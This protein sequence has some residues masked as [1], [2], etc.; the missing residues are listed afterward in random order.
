[1][2]IYDTLN[3]EQRE[4]VFCTE[5]PLLML[6][7][8]G[9]G[10]TRSLTHR[11]AYLIEEKGVAPWNILAITFTNKAA[12]EMRER[13]DALVGYGSEDIWI[14]TFHAT[15]SRILRRHIDL[16]GYDRNFT[17][18]DASDQKSLMKE[19]LKEMKIDTKQFPERS[20]MSEISS[21]K[22]EYK[23]P[24]DYRNEYGSNFRN[25]RIADIYEHY[26][27]RLK[28]NNALDFDDLLVKMVDLFQTNPDVLEHYQD[29]FQYIM[30]DEYQDTNTVQFLLVSLLAK[31]YRNLCVVGDDDQS[32]YKFRGANIYNILN[33][34]K[35]FPDAQVIR[36][37]QNYR[38][39]QNILNAANGVIANNKGRK[40]KKLW[41]EN[42]KGELVH[43]KQY[44]TEYDEADGVVSRINF[45]AMRGVQY[46][47]MA[48]LYRTNAQS[49]IFEE[50]LKQKNIPY[51]I[52]RGISFYD[53]KEIKDLMSY[54][55]V[56]DS[57]MDDLSV[58][59]IINVPKR[60]IGQTTINRLQ[61][62]A[63]LNQMSFLDAVFNADE[64]PEVTRALAKLHKFADMIEEFREY[65]SE[66]EISELLEHILDVTQYRAEL[67][68]EG[69][70]E[71]ISRLEDIEELFNDIAYYEE[72][73]E[74]PN[75]RD[76]LAEK[77][78]YT[79]N[80]GIDNLEDENNKVLLMTLHNAKGLEF[81]NVFLG[82]MEEGV[83]PGF[84]AMMSGDESEIEEERRLCYVGITRAKERLFLS[85]AKRRMLRGQTQYNRR[86]RFIDEIPGQY[87]DTEQRVSEQRVVKNTE[88]PAKYQYGAK[89][90]KPYN[91]SDFKVKPVGELDYQVGDRVKHIKFGV[92]TVQEIT[93]G[94]RDF[95]VAVEFDRVGRKKMF[96]SF[97]KLKKVK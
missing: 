85:A 89:A 47:D 70:D 93:K 59:R 72:E 57:G 3:N 4:A 92:G 64:I 75:L 37:E 11:I 12:Q 15:C 53:R 61:E 60:G 95:E 83:F 88:R 48:I 34:E 36:L 5:G 81:N 17:I 71:S 97:A 39:T 1:M 29:R 41:T 76:F 23:S 74:N 55:K 73:E 9:S 25:Q 21:A 45:L 16:L 69:T 54:L 46:K 84:G 50:K 49:R 51:A 14:S 38:S 8:A 30:V 68:A 18:Y 22:N 32:I 65:A 13:V 42:Q 90:G 40:E 31:K 27:K 63:I 6:A 28:E 52:V 80:A 82:G 78:M 7:G 56:V 35:V 24:L 79:L 26:Q 58:K 96:A 87:L 86:S 33:F 2:S 19:V 10:K 67:E 43:F 77:D 44:D 62:F 66:H 91:L 94:G 20:V